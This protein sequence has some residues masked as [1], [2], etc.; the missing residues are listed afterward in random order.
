MAEVFSSAI[1]SRVLITRASDINCCPSTTVIPSRCRAKRTGS[2]M[3]STPTGSLC[4]PRISSSM[5]IFLRHILRAPHLRRHGAAQHGNSGAR[6]LAQP[7]TMQLMVPGRRAEVPQN[8]L[9]VLRQQREAV[10]SCPAPK[11]RCGSRS[12][13]EHYSCRSKA[14]RPSPTWRAKSL[15]RCRR[16]VRRRSKSMRCSQSTAIVP[17]VGSAMMSSC[18]DT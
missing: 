13:S 11:C 6:A 9:V 5:R 3:M 12:D 7:G 2:S 1:S 17:C 10:R 4:R 18:L 15:A 8:G 16:S 14:A